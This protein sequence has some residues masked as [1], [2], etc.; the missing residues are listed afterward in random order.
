[1]S[2][3]RA[4]TTF[5]VLASLCA[6]ISIAQDE[7]KKSAAAPQRNTRSRQTKTSVRSQG[8]SRKATKPRAE[9]RK[10]AVTAEQ[11]DVAMAFARDN[12]P[13]L[14]PLISSL[15]E[16]RPNDYNRALRELHVAAARFGKLRERL[17][18]ERYAQQL[19]LW[20][21]DSRIK[22]QL[23]KWSVSPSKK[24]E[25]EIREAIAQRQSVRRQQYEQELLRAQDR[26]QKLQSAIQ[27]L[28][29]YS[30]DTEFDKLTKSVKRRRQSAKKPATRKK[31]ADKKT[32]KP[33][34]NKP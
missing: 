1:M 12:H 30:P 21:L 5:L 11:R 28:D 15:K 29:D 31:A 10:T 34:A 24:L 2:F 27:K 6:T 7:G 19:Q 32:Q 25:G 26:V 23:A 16:S 13:E 8:P 33:K 3:R 4:L 17:S 18:T 9:A 14:V 22:L 20:K